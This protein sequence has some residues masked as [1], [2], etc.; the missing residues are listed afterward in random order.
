MAHI[1]QEKQWLSSAPVHILAVTF[2]LTG[3]KGEPST[4]AW[5]RA[6]HAQFLSEGRAP[7]LWALLRVARELG[8]DSVNG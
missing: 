3:L 7:P 6:V 1:C 5:A 8:S 2:P 4:A